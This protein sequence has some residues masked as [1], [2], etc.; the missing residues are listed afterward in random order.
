MVLRK[1]NTAV[2]TVRRRLFVFLAAGGRVHDVSGGIDVVIIVAVVGECISRL[3]CE[4]NDKRNR[5]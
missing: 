3:R 5:R 4:A 1:T 2:A